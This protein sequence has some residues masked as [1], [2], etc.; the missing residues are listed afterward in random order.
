[1]QEMEQMAAD[2]PAARIDKQ[3]QAN[4]LTSD[5]YL[6]PPTGKHKDGNRF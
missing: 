1:M 6:L 5:N 4:E 3:P 2:G